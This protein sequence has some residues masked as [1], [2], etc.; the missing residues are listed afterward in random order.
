MSSK[1]VYENVTVKI[2]AIENE[3]ISE[4]PAACS[5]VGAGPNERPLSG[6]SP[7]GT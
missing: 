2:K 7:I 4:P 5:A 6:R 1:C 3:I